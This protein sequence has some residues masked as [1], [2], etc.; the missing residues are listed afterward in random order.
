MLGLRRLHWRVPFHMSLFEAPPEDQPS[1]RSNHSFSDVSSENKLRN[2]K[3][4]DNK[5]W[6]PQMTKP[7]VYRQRSLTRAP[8]NTETNI[9]R[10]MFYFTRKRKPWK[11]THRKKDLDNKPQRADTTKQVV[12]SMD[13]RLEKSRP[14]SCTT[15][16]DNSRTRL[17]WPCIVCIGEY[18][19]LLPERYAC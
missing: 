13:R 7:K 3:P 9:D 16:T 4:A 19:A 8:V 2:V 11:R 6:K 15:M 18:C 17:C 14:R 10:S 5:T 1:I 12:G